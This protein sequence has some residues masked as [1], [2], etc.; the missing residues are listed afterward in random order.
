MP[1]DVTSNERILLATDGS[2]PRRDV[3][4]EACV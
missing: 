4:P 1:G 3:V 2:T